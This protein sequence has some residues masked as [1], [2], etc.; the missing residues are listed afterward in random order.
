MTDRNDWEWT[1]PPEYEE[2]S[3]PDYD[4]M[5]DDIWIHERQKEKEKQQN[6]CY[7]LGDIK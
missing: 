3:E 1:N 5:N 7:S 6:N 4:K 2:E